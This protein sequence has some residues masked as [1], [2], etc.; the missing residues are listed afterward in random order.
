MNLIKNRQTIPNWHTVQVKAVLRAHSHQLWISLNRRWWRG[1]LDSWTCNLGNSFL[2]DNRIHLLV[3]FYCYVVAFCLWESRTAPGYSGMG[4]EE[5]HLSHNDEALQQ[6]CVVNIETSSTKEFIMA[7]VILTTPPFQPGPCTRLRNHATKL[8][9]K[10][11]TLF[12]HSMYW[13]RPI[14]LFII[15]YITSNKKHLKMWQDV[16]IPERQKVRK[17]GRDDR[18]KQWSIQPP[19]RDLVPYTCIM[20]KDV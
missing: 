11:S 9:Q 16:G 18:T 10:N 20:K 4:M 2:P 7:S 19:Y 1:T 6:L 5:S 14:H 12:L 3:E 17:Q 13:F 15:L 8:F